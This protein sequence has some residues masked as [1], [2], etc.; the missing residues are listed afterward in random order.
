MICVFLLRRHLQGCYRKVLT[1]AED[2]DIYVCIYR[3]HTNS[4]CS[5]EGLT[6]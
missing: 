6:W 5:I 2:A 1:Y 3:V 4:A